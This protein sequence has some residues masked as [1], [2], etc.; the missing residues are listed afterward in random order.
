MSIVA[1]IPDD[2]FRALL[3]RRASQAA[4]VLCLAMNVRILAHRQAPECLL[5]PRRAR[6]IGSGTAALGNVRC[7]DLCC[8]RERPLLPHYGRQAAPLPTLC[9]PRRRRVRNRGEPFAPPSS[10]PPRR[11]APV[12]GAA[13]AAQR[14]PLTGASRVAFEKAHRPASTPTSLVERRVRRFS[15]SVSAASR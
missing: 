9:S 13:S 3:P 5:L 6:P 4:M 1:S 11:A 15:Q 2:R 10:G 7:H 12:K 14:L 8:H